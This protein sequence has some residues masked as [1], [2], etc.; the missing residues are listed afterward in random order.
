[1]PSM[2]SLTDFA[3][4]GDGTSDDT[5]ILQEALLQTVEQ[6]RSLSIP[7]GRYVVTRPL[8]VDYPADAVRP[9]G[10]FAEGATIESQITDGSDLLTITSSTKNVRFLRIDG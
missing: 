1:M 6:G 3:V 2:T 10:I 4:S 5:A 7:P 8:T 9:H